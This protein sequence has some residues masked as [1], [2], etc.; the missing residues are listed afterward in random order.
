MTA[1]ALEVEAAV[2]VETEVLTVAVLLILGGVV[3]LVI[4]QIIS[5]CRRY[6]CNIVCMN[7]IGSFDIQRIVHR[8]IFL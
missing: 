6:M 4:L 2:V 1:A 8:D 5:L 7:V 3:M